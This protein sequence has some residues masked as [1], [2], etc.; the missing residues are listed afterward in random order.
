MIRILYTCGSRV[1]EFSEATQNYITDIDGLS[2]NDININETELATQ[3]GSSMDNLRVKP[4]NITFEGRIKY[5]PE[6]RAL[7]LSTV[8]PGRMAKIR[9]IDKDA[10]IDRYIEGTPNRTPD[11][12]NNPTWQSFQ[13]TFHVFFPY[14]KDISDTMISFVQIN[15]AFMLPRSF[16]S[17]EEWYISN[18]V[19]VPLQ[20]VYNNGS[21]DAGFIVRWTAG[22]DAKGPRFTKVDTQETISFS[23][24]SLQVGDIVEVS[25]YDDNKYTHL[26]RD[27]V[28]SNIFKYFDDDATFWKLTVGHNIV[29]GGAD[30]NEESV[31]C[32]LIFNNTYVGI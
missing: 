28:T 13:F 29:R 18:R 12:S 2:Y 7:I 9:Y 30:S 16:S 14:W 32:D 19:S 31:Y 21:T 15:S 1:L 11:F 8:I 17:T 25:T 27:G 22:A 4:K 24:L 6:K 10:G 23:G 3:A 5:T 20:T 26:I